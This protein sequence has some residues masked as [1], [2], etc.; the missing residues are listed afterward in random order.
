MADSAP[1]SRAHHFVPKCWLAGFTESGQN[2]G[3]LWVT[4]FK[5]KRN[6]PSTPAKTGLRRD[7]NRIDRPNVTDP[8]I[9]EKALADIEGIVA[10]ILRALNDDVREP[11]SDERDHILEFMALQ[12]IRHPAFRATIDRSVEAKI[13][14]ALV[15]KERWERLLRELGV[16]PDQPDM[17]YETALASLKSRVPFIA[18]DNLYYLLYG[19]KF[20]EP[21]AATFRARYWHARIDPRGNFIGS[22]NP[23]GLDGPGDV[24][25]GFTNASVVV[26]PVCRRVLMCGL[27]HPEPSKEANRKMVAELNTFAMLGAEEQ[28]YSH[29]EDFEFLDERRTQQRDWTLF[30]REKIISWSRG[31]SRMAQAGLES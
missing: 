13:E 16:P 5:R 4:D 18:G 20:A 7:F 6:W 15:S 22:D 1:E 23:V 30:N 10:P 2:D 14:A 31:Q 8:L 29:R 9:A 3:R 24:S 27:Q 26:Y 12:C 17:S 11:T 21:I 25:I 19:A 28:V